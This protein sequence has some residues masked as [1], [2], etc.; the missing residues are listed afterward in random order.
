MTVASKYHQ[1]KDVAE[2]EYVYARAYLKVTDAENADILAF[3]SG[4]LALAKTIL[5]EGFGYGVADFDILD[6]I[7]DEKLAEIRAALKERLGAVA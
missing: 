3:R 4:R 2:R 7:S 6:A 5:S 1:A